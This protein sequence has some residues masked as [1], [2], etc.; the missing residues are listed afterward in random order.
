VR[1]ENHSRDPKAADV[2]KTSLLEPGHIRRLF[3]TAGLS[4]SDFDA[5]LAAAR[6]D[7]ARGYQDSQ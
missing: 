2:D 4:G 7:R 1:T 3:K 6:D 5:Q